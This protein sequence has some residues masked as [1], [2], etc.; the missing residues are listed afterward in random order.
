MQEII[1]V[2]VVY[3]IIVK[4]IDKIKMCRGLSTMIYVEKGK[5]QEQFIAFI[6]YAIGILSEENYTSFLKLFDSRR[7]TERDLILALKYLDES[8]CAVKVDNPAQ[9]KIKNQIININ[10][11]NDDSGYWIDYDLTTD[12]EFNDLTIQIEFLKQKDEYLVVLDDLHTL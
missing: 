9:T 2:C 6:E 8:R 3:K 12:G 5:E 7:L 4:T 1:V 10:S 11:F